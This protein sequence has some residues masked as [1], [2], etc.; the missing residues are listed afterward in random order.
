MLI[1]INFIIML[2]R[3]INKMLQNFTNFA[4]LMTIHFH[5]AHFLVFLSSIFI[6]IGF[7]TLDQF[8]AIES[9][10]NTVIE[11]LFLLVQLS[12][13]EGNTLSVCNLVASCCLRYC[14]YSVLL[15]VCML[16]VYIR[17]RRPWKLRL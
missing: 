5:V 1:S 14:S 15:L 12:M 10:P 2:Q 11:H 8:L 17:L 13:V 3:S 4:H 6:R 16:R 7:L 9:Q